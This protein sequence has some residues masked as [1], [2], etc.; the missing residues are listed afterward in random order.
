ML[1]SFHLLGQP[2]LLFFR[3]QV[4][5]DSLRP[6]GL[7]PARPPWPSLSPGV[8]SKSCPFSQRCHP[9]ISPSVVP[10]SSCLQS[11]PASGSLPMSQ[12]FVSGVQSIGASALEPILPVNIQGWFPLVLM[13]LTPCCPR[14]S[15][16]SSP[17]PRFESINSLAL[18]LLYTPALTSTHDYWR[19]H[20]FDHMGL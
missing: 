14:D 10:F 6:R 18:C 15:Q 3:L 20:S 4:M 16:D 11:F 8:C 19:N 7:Q 1:Y 9:T 13:V 2:L 5:N 12:L 17:A